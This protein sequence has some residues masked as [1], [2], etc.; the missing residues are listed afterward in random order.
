MLGGASHTVGLS[1]GDLPHKALRAAGAVGRIAAILLALAG[2]VHAHD[3]YTDWKT[4]EGYSCCEGM[5]NHGDCRPTRAYV[6]DSGHWVAILEDGS[7]VTVPPDAILPF[8]SPDGRS[9]ICMS[10]GATQ[11]RCF[12][13]GEI[14]G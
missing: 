9:H 5:G 12:T 14:R 3:I 13:P 2:P 6:D 11:P 4:R 10:P 7:R 8:P 1:A